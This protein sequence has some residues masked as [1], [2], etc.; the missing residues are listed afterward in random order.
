MVSPYAQDLRSAMNAYS[1]KDSPDS[2]AARYEELS[3]ARTMF[4]E[5]GRENSRLTIP[6]LLPLE[7]SEIDPGESR[8]RSEERRVGKECRSRW[9]PYH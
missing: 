3:S 4:L 7:G 6:E 5:A 2:A 9:S 1:Y 8:R